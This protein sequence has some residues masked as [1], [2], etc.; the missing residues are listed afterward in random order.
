MVRHLEGGRGGRFC[1]Q[2][3]EC[4]IKRD[5][6][7]KAGHIAF[8]E[9]RIARLEAVVRLVSLVCG[10]VHT[11]SHRA[12]LEEAEAHSL[13]RIEKNL[14]EAEDCLIVYTASGSTSRY[15]IARLENSSII[16]RRL[17]PS[18][19]LPHFGPCVSC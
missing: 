11:C 12:D 2:S 10:G 8:V 17:S 6:Q 4:V 16:L 1:L 5:P 18:M 9:P 19:I 13:A 3:V 15:T 14:M 7:H